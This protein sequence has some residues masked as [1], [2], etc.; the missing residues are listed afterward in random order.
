[1]ILVRATGNSVTL[2]TDASTAPFSARPAMKASFTYDYSLSKREVTRGEYAAL[3][4][5]SVPDSLRDLPR[6][7]V[8]YYDAV[9]YA[10]LRS[11]A[12]GLDTVYTYASMTRSADGS[13]ASLEGLVT[14][15]G[16]G[17]YRLPTEAEWTYAASLGWDPSGK[18]W[19]SDNSGYAAHAACSAGADA[20]G[21]CDLAGNA[22]EWTEDWLGNFKDTAVTDFAGAPDGGSV[23]ERV[24]KGGSYRNAAA[25]TELYLRGCVPCSQR[26]SDT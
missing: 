11:A 21:F 7:D 22:L 26:T 14:H 13:C 18:A 4:G 17:G 10:N 3:A 20:S 6:T 24:V 15:L 23:G 25:N 16:R 9:L 2:G 5:G 19:T 8:T 1:M 12:E